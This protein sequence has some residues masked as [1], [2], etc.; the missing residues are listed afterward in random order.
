MHFALHNL[1]L[2]RQPWFG[3]RPNCT[4]FVLVCLLVVGWFCVLPTDVLASTPRLRRITPRGAQRGHEHQITFHGQRLSTTEE[5]LFHSSGMTATKI[6]IVSDTTVKVSIKV[7][8]D[9]RLGEHFMH[10]RTRHGIS[11][12]RSFHI[13]EL[14]SVAEKEPND[15][16]DVAQA[17]PLDVT[18]DGLIRADDTDFFCL[19]AEK[20]QRLSVEIQAMRLG[21][22]FD[23]L[24]ELY[25]SKKN[26]ILRSD[27]S[28]FAKQDGFF[29]ILTPKTDK[30]FIKVR[31]AEFGGS[32]RFN[33]RLHVGSFVRPAVV[34]PSGGKIGEQTWLTLIGDHWDEFKTIETAI[35]V[36]ES[37]GNE[38]LG[39]PPEFRS[40]T[41][42][43]FHAVDFENEF[44][45]EPNG[46]FNVV[47]KRSLQ[48]L[49]TP[50]TA[51]NGIISQPRDYDYFQ[52]AA[53]KGK[54][55]IVKCIAQRL[56]SG[57]DPRI[58]IYSPSLEHIGAN[59]DFG[60]HPDSQLEF[61]ATVDGNYF[62]RVHDQLYRGQLNFVY[63]IEIAEKQPAI[64]FGIKR[65][66]R[67]SQLRQVV[68]VPQ[69]GRYAVLLDVKKTMVPGPISFATDTL[70]LGIRAQWQ[71]LQDGT[72]LVPVVFEADENAELAGTLFNL[73]ATATIGSETDAA[74]TTVTGHFKNKA[75]LALG[76]PNN[77]VYTSGTIH[78]LPMAVVAALPFSVDFE[79]PTAPLVRNGSMSVPIVVTRADGFEG[80]VRV[81]L[82][83]RSPGVGARR[84]INIPKGKTTGNYPINANSSAVLGKWPIC[85]NATANFK[86]PAWTSSN[87]KTIEIHEAFVTTK[88][89]RVSV[90]RGQTSD[91]VCQLDH[92][93][94]FEGTATAKLL[95]LP[96]NV[97]IVGDDDSDSVSFD[98]TTKEIRFKVVTNDKSPIGKHNSLF[99]QL[100][101]PKNGQQMVSKAANC[102]L[103][104]R[105]SQPKSNQR[106]QPEQVDNKVITQ[107]SKQEAR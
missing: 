86:G 90:E 82:L 54:T 101:I 99:C 10:L 40:P 37:L 80:N 18:V 72:T 48:K 65:V 74:N 55:Y 100:S 60:R 83:F 3:R 91:I 21:E 2:F 49:A 31:D 34:F 41:P 11:D 96:P 87:L 57:L 33:Y 53:K 107:V 63:R 105:P 97:S 70:P 94:A 68:T 66:D 93:F 64:N 62:V 4:W 81:E 78:Q 98:A 92:H 30:Y 14:P 27:D 71:P 20:G 50:P 23:P 104:I 88:I 5:V 17:I 43:L 6:E 76:P 32:D 13:G 73:T 42:P 9:C 39:L 8:S 84:F 45:K 51:L 36:T 56:G 79:T 89:D 58:K 12:F 59:D 19:E 85:F 26:L 15:H 35:T 69:G 102:T 24:L 77:F 44:E 61:K 22:F 38:L 67:N 75:D 16:F 52:F 1:N 106:D 95:G 29:S 46:N 28:D 103:L 7:D 47:K 25:D